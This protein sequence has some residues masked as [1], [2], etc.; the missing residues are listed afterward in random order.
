M[1]E[2]WRD[3]IG[4][5]GLY[6]VSNLGNVKK[7]K[8]VPANL[9][10]KK[11]V[12]LRKDKTIYSIYHRVSLIKKQ[13]EKH[14]LVHRLVAAAFTSNP[15]NKPLVNH[16]DGNPRNNCAD[17]LE[18]CTHQENMDHYLQYINRKPRS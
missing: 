11:V 5:E 10:F 15:D 6:M 13:K 1:N 18:W 14:F 7:L 9:K 4:Y 3:I 8:G 2:E 12:N 17:N 16:I